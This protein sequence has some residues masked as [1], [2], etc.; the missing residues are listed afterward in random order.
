M[1][2]IWSQDGYP[3]GHAYRDYHHHTSHNHRLWRNDG[4][5]YDRDG[6]LA[7]AAADASDFV[8]RVIARVSG[9]GVCV[10]AL[11]TELLGHW[12]YEGIEWLALVIEEAAR[13]GL[14][15][16]GLDD[17]I[18]RHPPTP[19]PA[20]LQTTTWGE[21]GDLRTWSGP[22]VAE[23]AWSAR[24]A[25]LE[26]VAAGE[27]APDRALRELLAL[28]SS[29]WAFLSSRRL[30]GDYPLQRARR[31]RE[32][33]DRALAGDESLE[34]QLRGLAPDLVRSFA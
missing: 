10:C 23:L 8:S 2:L 33:M 24:T 1:A 25:E 26:L 21:G 13:R 28:Q 17:A 19:A 9:G 18:E 5:A 4:G 27:R 30:A 7:Q 32:L 3:A 29:D 34:P 11:D 22:A 15:L 31:H 16:T 6:A 12:W 14:V 20:D